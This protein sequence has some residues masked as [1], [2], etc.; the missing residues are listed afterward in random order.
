VLLGL[1]IVV[2]LVVVVVVVV[3]VSCPEHRVCQDGRQL[4]INEDDG[5]GVVPQR[6]HRPPT[7]DSMSIARMTL[8]SISLV[9][10]CGACSS[11]GTPK[12][13]GPANG[14]AGSG[15]AGASGS[16]GQTA[17]G[18][19][20]GGPPAGGSGGAAA[21][22]TGA[23]AAPAPEGD[24]GPSLVDGGGPVACPLPPEPGKPRRPFPQH[25]GYPGCPSCIHPG[26]TQEAMDADVAAFYGGWKRLLKTVAGGDIAG[27]YVV[28]AGAAGDINGW[29][30]GVGPATQSEGHGYGMLIL[31]LMAGQDPMARMYFDSMN[32]VRKTFPSSANPKLMSWVVP[33]TGNKALAPQPPATDGDMDMAYALLLAHDQWGEEA[34]THY[35]ADARSIIDGLETSCITRGSGQYFPRLNIGDPAHLGS[36]APESK[37]FM[38]RPSDFMVDHMR[39]FGVA[40]G[41]SIWS[42]VESG[43]LAIL[44]AVRNPTTGLVPD[45]VVADPPV[46]S[47]TGTADEAVCYE[48]YDYNSCRVPWRQAVAIAHHGVAGS[49]DVAD[50][51]VTWARGKYGDNPGGMGSSF[52]LDGTSSGGNDNSFASPMVA[53]S[54]TSAAHQAWLDKGWAYM[55]ASSRGYYGGSITLM[56]MLLVSGNWWI[57][58]GGPPGCN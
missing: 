21:G 35:L 8:V 10:L 16:A 3:V 42:E 6:S 17:T 26:V 41:H 22:S 58:S 56:S 28:S 44:L 5:S 25:V 2:V 4:P 52:T 40:S 45:F 57:P 33:Q 18:G 36:G 32:R 51:M 38:T 50:K 34:T 7:E 30:A 54:I 39:A 29:P 23:D 13:P 49:R 14:G 20:G 37:P 47:K 53:A 27:E 19:T 46:P 24:G 15:G 48:C 1:T 9:A 11:G 31:A 43:S 12:N 55:K